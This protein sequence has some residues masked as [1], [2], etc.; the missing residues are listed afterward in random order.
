MSVLKRVVA[1]VITLAAITAMTQ[2]ARADTAEAM[3]EVR[4]HGEVKR[5]ASGPCTF[6]QR[7]GYVDIKL[8][9][10]D[11]YNLSPGNKASHF[12]DQK[13]RHVERTSAG[14]NSQTYKWENK[15]IIVTFNGDTTGQ[16]RHQNH[17]SPGQ[18]GDTPPNLRDL[19]GQKGG[20]AEDQLQERGYK[21]KNSSKSGGAIY[22]NWKEKSSGRCVT[23]RTKDGRYKSIVYST[24]YDCRQ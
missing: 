1:A 2:T 19:V 12:K 10:G 18:V 14:G 6:S 20:Q 11:T 8:R 4:Q 7:R 22:T 23:I 24:D 9:N 21:L 16:P 13:D 15:K 5:N 3:C 17:H